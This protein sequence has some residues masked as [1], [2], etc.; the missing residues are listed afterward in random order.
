[1]TKVMTLQPAVQAAA[2]TSVVLQH[3]KLTAK[4]SKASST[5]DVAVAA[6]LA[7]N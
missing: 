1:M 6:A 4:H 3:D 5:D 2:A 7:G